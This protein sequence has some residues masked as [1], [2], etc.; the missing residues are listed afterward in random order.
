MCVNFTE[1]NK[2]TPNRDH[3]IQNV[4]HFKSRFFS[5]TDLAKEFHQIDIHP[6]DRQKTSI[7]IETTQDAVLTLIIWM[8]KCTRH[9]SKVA[10]NHPERKS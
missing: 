2:I 5:T 1:V 6:L 7:I 4:G 8:D 3:L 9:L 10:S